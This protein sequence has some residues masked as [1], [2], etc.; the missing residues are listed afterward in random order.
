[1]V[2]AWVL[3]IAV[4]IVS[5]GPL[6][7]RVNAEFSGS[8]RIESAR[9]LERIQNES[10][11]GGDIA[12][13]I[14]GVSV[15]DPSTTDAITQ[16]LD[17]I[18]AVDGVIAVTDPWRIDLPELVATDGDAALAV[19][20]FTNGL[21]TEAEEALAEQVV[22]LA[23]QLADDGVAADV[24]VGGET[25]VFQEFEHQAEEDLRRGEAIALPIALIAMVLIFGG[26]RAA[27]MPLAVAAAGFLTS[28]ISLLGATFVL[29]DVSVF[30]INVVSMLGIGLGIDYGLL[31]VSRFREERG[32][33]RDMATAVETLSL[34]HI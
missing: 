32:R 9:V 20:S 22:E 21:D 2:G 12:I 23:H 16:Q 5:S 19:V 17:R 26:F 28:M 18:A 13:V 7:N 34:I 24:M 4:G 8:D 6:G 10:A 29:D 1:V 15:T 27:G 33:G 3:V 11:T 25:I 30:A 14:D 31:L